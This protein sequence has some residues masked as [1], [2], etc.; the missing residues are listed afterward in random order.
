MTTRDARAAVAEET[1]AVLQDGSYTVNFEPVN[2]QRVLEYAV[3][4]T[5]FHPSSETLSLPEPAGTFSVQIEVTRET[6]LEAGRRLHSELGSEAASSAL[7][8]L[9][10]ASAKNP[11][12]GFQKGSQ[13]QEE[14]LARSSGLYSCLEPH[15]RYFYAPNQNDPNDGLYSHAMLYSPSVPFFREDWGT[16]CPLWCASV[17]TAPAPNAGVAIPRCGKAVVDDTLRE[18]CR[19][20]LRLAS[21]RGHTDLVLGAYGCGVFKNDPKDVATCFFSILFHLEEFRRRFRRI[22][23]AIP[24]REDDVNLLAFQAQ[25][26]AIPVNAVQSQRVG[27]GRAAGTKGETTAAPK[28]SANWYASGAQPPQPAQASSSQPPQRSQLTQTEKDFLKVVKKF[29]GIL[30]IKEEKDVG[31]SVEKTQ[32]KKLA[33]WEEVLKELAETEQKLSAD[34][35]LREKNADVL[36]YL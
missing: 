14:S 26:A 23:F 6:T 17:I 1:L 4:N 13:A 36:Q 5:V 34:S 32:E 31:K 33:S 10:F 24:G 20:I 3:G 9:N 2:I 27:T 30:K 35:A 7:C 19:R 15:Q 21:Y 25:F 28:H 18:R 12:G 11:G 22:V 8:V 29:R 16:F